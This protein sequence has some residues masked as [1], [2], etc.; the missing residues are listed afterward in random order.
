[1]GL[2]LPVPSLYPVHDSCGA[3][4]SLHRGLQATRLEIKNFSDEE[5]FMLLTTWMLQRKYLM[6]DEQV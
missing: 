4:A 2:C 5:I 3:V 1:M 6:Q